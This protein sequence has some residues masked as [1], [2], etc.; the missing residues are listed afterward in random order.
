MKRFFTILFHIVIL[1]KR[2]YFKSLDLIGMSLLFSAFYWILEAVR[3]VI[4]FERGDILTRIFHPDFISFWMRL[5]VVCVIILFGA[6]SHHLKERIESSETTIRFRRISGNVFASGF[7]FA[8]SYWVLES[9][10]DTITFQKGSFLKCLFAP[11]MTT[12]WMR[13]LAFF[14]ILLFS[15]YVQ[16]LLNQQK[17]HEQ[18]L[19]D[20]N[21]TLEAMVR[22]RTNELSEINS[23]LQQ[24]I[25]DRLNAE[26]DVR[27]ANDALKTLIACNQVMIRAAD[28]ESLLNRICD[29]LIGTGDFRLVWISY[30]DKEKDELTTVASSA[31]DHHDMNLLDIHIEPHEL[32]KIPHGQAIKNNQTVKCHLENDPLEYTTWKE[33]ARK[34]H[35]ETLISLPI[36]KH[37]EAIGSLNMI[38][39]NVSSMNAVKVTLFEQLVEDLSFGI[40][41]M[42][43][44]EKQSI[45]ER[46]KENI[47]EQLLHSQKMEAVGVLAG[48]VAHDFNNLLTAIQVSADLALMQLDENS[49]ACQELNE[50]H[51]VAG[52]ASDLAKQLLLFSRKH[53]MAYASYNLNESIKN[54]RKMLRRVIGENIEVET[55]LDSNLWTIWGDRGTIEQVVMNIVINAKDAMPNGGKITIKTENV[56]LNKIAAKTMAEGRRGKFVKLTIRDTGIGMDKETQQHIFEPFFSTKGPGKGTGLGLSVVYGIVKEHKGWVHLSSEMGNGSVFQIYL[57]AVYVRLDDESEDE[58][59]MTRL[60]GNGKHVLLIEDEE[61]VREYTVKGLE[62]NDY[63]VYPACSVE[64][65]KKLFQEH[66]TE[67]ELLFSDIGLPDGNGIDLAVNFCKENP[68]LKVVLSSGYA[69][70]NGRAG[71]VKQNGYT[72]LQ[73]PFALS[74]LLKVLKVNAE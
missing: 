58:M 72:F 32:T 66:H 63:I 34:M 12:S 13:L 65:A 22:E 51:H 40:Q 71:Q 48:G 24:E 17:A 3:D 9:I 68:A 44:R 6:Y 27:I 11:D 25:T 53:P 42:R 8:I 23:K 31:L 70:Q 38:E 74:E 39:K 52:H 26:Q 4:V 1:P 45:Y 36:I 56:R 41:V 67:I 60:R 21:E 37:E 73:K 47:Q 61:K 49:P 62:Q 46:E 16:K 69:I 15:A 10:R 57:P 54:L 14:V 20:Y 43:S 2:E 5:L 7:L 18:S 50:I 19:L 33:Q 64:Q 59:D 30:L 35:F 28:E 29:T 55:L